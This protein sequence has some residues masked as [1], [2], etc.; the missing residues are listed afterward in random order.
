MTS[1]FPAVSGN[2]PGH[3][4]SSL[5]N[6]STAN[7]IEKPVWPTLHM[8]LLIDVASRMGVAARLRDNQALTK[9]VTLALHVEHRVDISTWKPSN[10]C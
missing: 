5:V 9:D 3:W 10:W 7:A 1:V 6:H 8:Q 2:G 4:A